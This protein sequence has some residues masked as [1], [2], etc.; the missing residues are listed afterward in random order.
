M[1]HGRWLIVVALLGCAA[2]SPAPS[3]APQPPAA[4]P[5]VAAPR[6]VVERISLDLQVDSLSGMAAQ[7]L[8]AVQA[9][10]G[11]VASSHVSAGDGQGRWTLRIP[12]ARTNEFL[13]TCESWGTVLSRQSSAED[14]TEQ[15]VD[16]NARLISKRLEE[17]RLQ[18]L[19]A[20]KTGNLEEIL[21]D[22][23]ELGRVR[24]EIEQA[25]GRQRSLE[26]QT[27]YAT[28]ELTVS[29]KPQ[30][31]APT[32]AVPVPLL[33]EMGRVLY[34]SWSLLLTVLRFLLLILV[35]A[36][37][38]TVILAIPAT[39]IWWWWRA[40]HQSATAGSSSSALAP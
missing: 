28:I 7:I 10:E 14:V 15:Y 40:R 16:V 31:I 1:K 23:R 17:E 26:H 29:E 21:I 24:G 27:A 19:L 37:P 5:A 9:S 20:E 30:P 13:K 2:G 8:T 34:D 32:L 4:A 3:S 39:A 38:W 6:M 33:Q 18:K 25:Q 11:Y 22:E 36:L 35:A 12:T